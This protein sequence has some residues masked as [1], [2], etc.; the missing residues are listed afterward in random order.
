MPI[1]VIPK[2]HSTDL[3]LVTDYSA[4]DHA[5]D[6][7]IAHADSS[8]KLDNHQHFGSTLLGVIVEHG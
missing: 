6:S 5:L 4:G 8:I 2:P 1:R 3:H 7:F